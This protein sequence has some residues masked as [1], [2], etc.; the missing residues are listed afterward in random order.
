[1]YDKVAEAAR[2]KDP[3]SVVHVSR[4]GRRLI[5]F[6]AIIQSVRRDPLR[7]RQD[8]KNSSEETCGEKNRMGVKKGQGGF[9]QGISVVIFPID[10]YVGP[11]LAEDENRSTGAPRS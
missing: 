9:P 2:K 7:D 5:G 11:A 8:E 6:R 1:M 10:L 3:R 4:L